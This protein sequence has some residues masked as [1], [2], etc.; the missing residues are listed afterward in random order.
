M[1]EYECN[2]LHCP[3]CDV[4]RAFEARIAKGDPEYKRV[5]CPACGEDLGEIRADAGCQYIGEVGS[6]FSC[7]IRPGSH[8]HREA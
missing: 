6:Q 2:W 1:A 3:G 4:T 7:T 8:P 5:F